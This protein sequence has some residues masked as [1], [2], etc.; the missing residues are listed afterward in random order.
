MTERQ[1]RQ[2]LDN[3]RRRGPR[4][5]F[6]TSAEHSLLRA[7][8]RGLRRQHAVQDAWERLAS[9]EWI[10]RAYVGSVQDG[11][12]EID[13]LDAILCRRLRQLAPRLLRDL[14]PAAPGLRQVHIRLAGESR[15][16][17]ESDAS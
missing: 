10:G 12:V 4:P 14:T 2:V 9:P 5:L 15:G 17:Q 16:I 13:V 8:A 7:A 6:S 1:Y 11:I 3:R